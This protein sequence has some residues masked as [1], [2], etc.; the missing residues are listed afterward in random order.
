MAAHQ[1]ASARNWAGAGGRRTFALDPAGN[2]AR[3][4]R[5]SKES[6][7]GR[8]RTFTFTQ[9]KKLLWQDL[10]KMAWRDL[11]E[12]GRT[13]KTTEAV[14]ADPVPTPIVATAADLAP[15]VP[16]LLPAPAVIKS[17]VEMLD[18]GESGKPKSQRSA[19]PGTKSVA[20][21]G[22]LPARMPAR[23]PALVPVPARVAPSPT[24]IRSA[25]LNLPHRD[26]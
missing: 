12:M 2:D 13:P 19:K 23:M 9:P 20:S 25:V 5:F 15:A 8:R 24:L 14:A 1:T 6:L 11:A 17:M 26:A 16:V 22:G 3:R 10:M 7:G 18:A 4:P 21:T